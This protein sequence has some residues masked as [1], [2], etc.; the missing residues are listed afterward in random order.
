V[1]GDLGVRKPGSVVISVTEQ[2][3]RQTE[4]ILEG[5]PPN[6]CVKAYLL[7]QESGT[8]P[9]VASRFECEYHGSIKNGMDG[10]SDDVLMGWFDSH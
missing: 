1:V 7:I 5:N 3:V 8:Q 4:C 2:R 9:T 6:N 10:L